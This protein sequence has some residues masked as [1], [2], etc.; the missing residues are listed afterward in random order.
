M[1]NFVVVRE[2]KDRILKDPGAERIST[3]TFDLDND[4]VYIA[5]EK[6]S[7][8]AD[9]VTVQIWSLAKDEKEN[10]VRI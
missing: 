1:R 6:V 8:A 3:T 2:N 4:V 5:S 10:N 9:E 7:A